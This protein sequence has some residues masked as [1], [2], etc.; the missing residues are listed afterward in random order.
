MLSNGSSSGGIRCRDV[1][2]GD[3]GKWIETVVPRSRPAFDLDLAA[4]GGN[5]GVGDPQAEPGSRCGDGVARPA[6][7]AVADLALLFAG[8]ARAIVVDREHDG[9]AVLMGADADRRTDR[10]VFGG[11]VENLHQRLLDLRRID[12]NDRQIRIEIERYRIAGEPPPPMLERGVDDVDR[13]D[14]LRFR[15]HL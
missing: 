12:T 13:L 4:V 1:G 2:C 9:V 10:R 3:I 15:P 8:K 7:E 6:E 5:K 14:P 11:I